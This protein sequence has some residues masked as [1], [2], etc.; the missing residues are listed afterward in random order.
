MEKGFVCPMPCGHAIG[1]Q[2]PWPPELPGVD[3]WA[4]GDVP[5]L[6]AYVWA[7]GQRVLELEAFVSE[8]SAKVK[9]IEEIGSLEQAFAGALHD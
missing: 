2:M 6:L 7:I 9:A 5:T 8:L 1:F 3:N 4:Y